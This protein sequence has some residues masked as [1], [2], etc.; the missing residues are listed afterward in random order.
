MADGTLTDPYHTVHKIDETQFA[1]LTGKLD[2]LTQAVTELQFTGVV[3][4]L[5]DFRALLVGKSLTIT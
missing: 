3:F 5:G 1:E 4:E 2:A